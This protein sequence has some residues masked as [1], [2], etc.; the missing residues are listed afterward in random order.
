MT[1][2]IA[3]GKK[4]EAFTYEPPPATGY[5]L[6]LHCGCRDAR[7]FPSVA[8]RQSSWQG[9]GFS[10]HQLDGDCKRLAARHPLSGVGSGGELRSRRTPIHFLSS[11]SCLLGATLSLLLPLRVVPGAYAWLTLVL[12]GASMNRLAKGWMIPSRATL[13]AVL[14]ILNPYVLINVFVRSAYGELLSAVFLPLVLSEV[15]GLLRDDRRV[16]PRLALVLG[17]IWL[18]NLPSAVLATFLVALGAVLGGA[19][20]R[21][22]K[23]PLYGGA[24]I[25]LAFG[26]AGLPF[27]PALVEQHWVM[28]Q[29]VVA[30]ALT[31][32]AN[33]IFG[34]NSTRFM[35]YL[36]LAEIAG[37]VSGLLLLSRPTVRPPVW[38]AVRILATMGAF[39]FLLML[40]ISLPLWKILPKLWFV[41]FNWRWLLVTNIVVS[42]VI[43]ASIPKLPRTLASVATVPLFLFSTIYLARVGAWNAAPEFLL[44]VQQLVSSGA[45]YYGA[46][47][48]LPQGAIDYTN[49]PYRRPKVTYIPQVVPQLP[50]KAAEHAEVNVVQWDSQRR[51]LMAD[52][53][54]PATVVLNLLAYPAWRATLNGEA[55]PL[56]MRPGSGLVQLS[57]PP[58]HSVIA[59]DFALTPD[60]FYGWGLSSICLFA[61]IGC[62]IIDAPRGTPCKS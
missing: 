62:L 32:A 21:S 13:A 1:A 7:D 51:T 23:G 33:F 42:F 49:P 8:V 31:P 2:S 55:H 52:A 15:L 47:E 35:N 19:V 38:T 48:Y 50:V 43:A 30:P 28:I 10:S 58:G 59:L 18:T 45:G 60:R 29:Q 34:P 4:F 44:S 27:I 26:L 46:P 16:I 3:E 9:P 39:A 6:Q 20:T 5:A 56:E 40:S 61:I 14:Y 54:Q 53:Q 37:V 11:L 22:W 12:G 41:Q 25:A 57:I 24:P 17:L 36:V